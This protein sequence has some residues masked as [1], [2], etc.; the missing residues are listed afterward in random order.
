MMLKEAKKVNARVLTE[1]DDAILRIDIPP[2]LLA[3]VKDKHWKV[4]LNCMEYREYTL[5]LDMI[6]MTRS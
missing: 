6:N 5:H 1:G 3:L 2:E 4:E